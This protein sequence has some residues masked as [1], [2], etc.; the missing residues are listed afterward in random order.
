MQQVGWGVLGAGAIAHRFV[1]D[2]S[3][4]ETGVL[5]AV[6]SR[7]IDRA[8]SC[9]AAGGRGAR[10]AK[11]YDN[12]AA[13]LADPSVDVVYV[14]T[15]TAL[16]KDHSLMALA[17]GKPV[18]CEKPMAMNASEAREVK[19]AA[20]SAGLFFME[21]MWTLCLPN[22]RKAAQLIGSGAIGSV[23]Q[24]QAS[25]GFPTQ[26]VE[27]D[28]VTDPEMGGGVLRDLAVYPLS[29][30]RAFLGPLEVQSCHISQSDSGADRDVAALLRAPAVDASVVIRA[31][32]ATR[33]Q[34]GLEISGE[35]G[36]ILIDPPFLAGN[37]IRTVSFAPKQKT[38]VKGGGL[39]QKL[40]AS[41][42]WP[43]LYRLGRVA[44]PADGKRIGGA[45]RGSGLQFAA[46]EVGRALS[47]GLSQIENVS[48]SHA[49]D[50]LAL[51][52]SI[53][54]YNKDQ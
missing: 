46:D 27:G 29:V 31:S 16:H 38:A 37:A 26:E 45:Y 20:Q 22:I 54:S 42:L 35:T 48:I 50:V 8:T 24:F 28:P 41:S 34:N 43:G 12:Y 33:L 30:A 1:A 53:R 23:V 25:L 32:H 6:A 10:E 9:R 5:A 15:P 17:A 44:I 14:A 3:L 2:L 11:V 52:D 51:V 19:D 13:L 7:Q 21:N 36:R 4:S 47:A 39:G 49:I 18:L 40:R